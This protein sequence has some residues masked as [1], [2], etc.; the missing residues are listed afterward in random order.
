MYKEEEVNEFL[1]QIT[2]DMDNLMSELR[3]TQEENNRLVSELERIRESEGSLVETLTAAKSLMAD[4]SASADKRAEVLLKNA[5]LDAELMRKSAREDIEALAK[6]INACGDDMQEESKANEF[7][8]GQRLYPTARAVQADLC[9]QK[10]ALEFKKYLDAEEF[11]TR[12]VGGM[13]ISVLVNNAGFGTYGPFEN[14]DTIREMEMIDTDC[15]S[16]TGITGFALPYMHE[17]SRIINTASLA[18][19]MPLGNFAVYGACKAYVLSF[20]V[21]LA[22]ELKDRGISVTAMCPG[23]VSTEFAAVASR[24]ARKA[25]KH[26]LSPEKTVAHCLKKSRKGKHYALMAFKWKFKAFASTFVPRYAGAWFTY[27]FCPRPSN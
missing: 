9:G 5:E 8:K 12:S 3:E 21:A 2:I 19:Y 14:T 1:D 6:E 24:G 26:G 7:A 23:P 22:A 4:I 13:H 18:S 10:G 17:G 11:A 20:S 25:V 15:T 16:L 27:R